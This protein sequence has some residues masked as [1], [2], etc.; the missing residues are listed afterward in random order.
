MVSLK[1]AGLRFNSKMYR[2]DDLPFEGTIEPDAEGKIIGYDYS[3]PRRLLRVAGDCQVKTGDVIRDVMERWYLVADHDASFAYN[4]VE[5]RTQMLIPLNK[6]VTWERETTIV[7]PLT[8]REK[9][10]G[11]TLLENIWVLIERVNREQMDS[12]LRVKEE[13]VTC[14][15]AAE[16]KL[17]DIVDGMVVK[18]V[19][20][21]RGVY[22]TELQ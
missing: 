21:V 5:F 10:S 2:S 6:N 4:V 20:I 7:D 22:L 14:F 16:L 15:S 3:Y 18:R 1:T 17:G 19:N 12:T 13:T 8:K 9:S 11:K